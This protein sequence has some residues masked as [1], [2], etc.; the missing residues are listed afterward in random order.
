VL[1]LGCAAGGNL[2]PMAASSPDSQFVGIDLSNVQITE[3]Q[4][5]IKLWDWRTSS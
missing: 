2:M 4:E 3:G 1:E 5:T